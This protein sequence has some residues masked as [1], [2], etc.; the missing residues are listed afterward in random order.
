MEAEGAEGDDAEDV[1]MSNMEAL[2]LMVGLAFA[3]DVLELG[4]VGLQSWSIW[5]CSSESGKRSSHT[6]LHEVHQLVSLV[7][8]IQAP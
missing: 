8:I 5:F 2:R 3:E 1:G 6:G 7:R 4:N